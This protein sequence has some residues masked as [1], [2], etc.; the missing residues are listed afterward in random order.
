MNLDLDSDFEFAESDDD[1]E[2]ENY[3][4]DLHMPVF[5]CL[6]PG[7]GNAPPSPNQHR[8]GVEIPANDH[9]CAFLPLS[10]AVYSTRFALRDNYVT[11]PQLISSDS[12]FNGLTWAREKYT[13][14]LSSGI[15]TGRPRRFDY[16]SYRDMHNTCSFY[17][18]DSSSPHRT[19]EFSRPFS[20]SWAV[21]GWTQHARNMHNRAFVKRRENHDH[22]MIPPLCCDIEKRSLM[23]TPLDIALRPKKGA[24]FG[25]PIFAD[26]VHAASGNVRQH[27]ISM[28]RSFLHGV[29]HDNIHK[30]I[31]GYYPMQSDLWDCS[32]PAQQQSMWA[33]REPLTLTDGFEI[34]KKLA[35]KDPNSWTN[36]MDFLPFNEKCSWSQ[37]LSSATCERIY[38]VKMPGV[39]QVHKPKWNA[40]HFVFSGNLMGGLYNAGRFSLKATESAYSIRATYAK[41]QA[42]SVALSIFM[43]NSEQSEGITTVGSAFMSRLVRAREHEI[44]SIRHARATSRKMQPFVQLWH[45]KTTYDLSNFCNRHGQRRKAL[46]NI[47][48]NINDILVPAI[49]SL[50]RRMTEMCVTRVAMDGS[51]EQAHAAA[52]HN[53][54]HYNYMQAWQDLSKLTALSMFN[55]EPDPSE[56]AA[57]YNAWQKHSAHC[58]LHGVCPE[59][60]APLLHTQ[61]HVQRVQTFVTLTHRY[62]NKTYNPLLDLL[63]ISDCAL[64]NDVALE[65]A[66]GHTTVQNLL[67]YQISC[68]IDLNM[69]HLY[70]HCVKYNYQEMNCSAS[71]GAIYHTCPAGGACYGCDCH[72]GT[73]EQTALHV[74][75][76]FSH[77]DKYQEDWGKS[78]FSDM[79][80]PPTSYFSAPKQHELHQTRKRH[81]MGA[82]HTAHFMLNHDSNTIPGIE[83]LLNGN[84]TRFNSTPLSTDF[85]RSHS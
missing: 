2:Y 69:Q 51:A 84:A 27:P 71:K 4:E 44:A 58:R 59:F 45:L 46:V 77:L 70:G 63:C 85:F 55:G 34:L 81:A 56:T 3:F 62:M 28:Y 9:G 78:P 79:H 52:A 50:C 30:E 15:I 37:Y 41:N 23:W 39:M 60:Q 36:V 10:T 53:V 13:Y 20:D 19:H 72:P 66:R 29:D 8:M 49:E 12:M 33:Q 31:K 11:V 6:F 83:P 82:A 48:N 57:C 14:E 25:Q 35:G 18:V 32:T 1:N 68:S 47:G 26:Y 74:E 16:E 7:L 22:H 17:V 54:D 38:G 80:L 21:S 65:A 67:L 40:Q 5:P 73:K 64:R 24:F 43:A 61:W 76:M 42:V 75:R